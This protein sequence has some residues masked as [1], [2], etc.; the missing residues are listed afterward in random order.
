M[1]GGVGPEPSCSAPMI[2]KGPRTGAG[3]QPR[4]RGLALLTVLWALAILALLAA[5]V[6]GRSTGDLRLA[7]HLE[8]RAQAA[9]AADAA[10]RLEI[11]RLLA[12]G[13][14]AWP[15]DG[16]WRPARLGGAVARARSVDE[17]GL[18]DVNFAAP[19]L[20]AALAGVAGAPPA[21]ADAFAAAVVGLRR[22]PEGD[23][24]TPDEISRAPGVDAVLL[25]RLAPFLTTWTAAR[26]P[27]ALTAP[28]EVRAALALLPQGAIVEAEEERDSAELAIMRIRRAAARGRLGDR[29]VRVE[30]EAEAA[31]GARFARTAVVALELGPPPRWRALHWDRKAE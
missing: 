2:S 12:D 24:A 23:L 15:P 3:R 16:A 30:A 22:G 29:F 10:V 8:G 9:L 17:A 5:A 13:G 27:N 4:A 21:E 1:S 28:P 11:A 20:L 14:T 7:R 6:L 18:V 19:Q 31:G 25:R 26:A